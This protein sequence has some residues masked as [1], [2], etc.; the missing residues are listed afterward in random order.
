MSCSTSSIINLH[1]DRVLQS[2]T[3]T[4]SKEHNERLILN[5]IYQ[6]LNYLQD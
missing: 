4:M 5:S 2:D 3:C 1:Y 6:G